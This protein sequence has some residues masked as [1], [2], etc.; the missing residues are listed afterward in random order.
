MTNF[1]VCPEI[2]LLLFAQSHGANAMKRLLLVFHMGSLKFYSSPVAHD[3]LP[4]F[5]IAKHYL[6]GRMT[7]IPDISPEVDSL[8]HSLSV[9]GSSNNGLL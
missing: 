7:R 4:Y 1:K 5:C 3:I 9:T 8:L 6:Q 2:I